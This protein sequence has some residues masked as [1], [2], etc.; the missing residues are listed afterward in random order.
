MI[1]IC[2]FWVLFVAVALRPGD[3][4][5]SQSRVVG[6]TRS[7]P[8]PLKKKPRVIHNEDADGAT[9]E[10]RSSAGNIRAAAEEWFDKLLTTTPTDIVVYAGAY[11][12]LVWLHNC[13]AGEKVY[14]RPGLNLSEPAGG[15]PAEAQQYE[16]RCLNELW[17][18]DTDLLQ[19]AVD[20]AHARGRLA[21]AEMRMS[22]Y[23]HGGVVASSYLCPKS[24]LDHPE[25]RL[26]PTVGLLDYG[27]PEVRALYLS[28]LRDIAT[29]YQVDGIELNWF[30]W[31]K[32]FAM[33]GDQ[34]GGA[35]TLTNWLIDVRRM[36]DDVSRAQ[37]RPR[38][39]LTHI[40]PATVPESLV[41]GCDVQQW[42]RKGLA[43]ILMPM[44][45]L[46]ADFNQPTVDFIAV[47]EGTSTLVYPLLHDMLTPQSL[48]TLDN[49][50]ALAA[51]QKA[52]GADGLGSFNLYTR[53][54]AWIEQVYAILDAPAAGHRGARHYQ[55]Q[56]GTTASKPIEFHEVN[57]KHSFRYRIAESGTD[58]QPSG[59]MRWRIDG[60]SK[61][62]R[63]DFE[64]NGDPLPAEILT[65]RNL[66]GGEEVVRG[67]T[68]GG[69]RHETYEA[70]QCIEMRLSDC[71][72]RSGDNEL[73][74]RW[75]ARDASNP[76]TRRL[77]IMELEVDGKP[78]STP[79][80]GQ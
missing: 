38:M 46:F 76:A 64:L 42:I 24:V 14:T 52:A 72:M 12:D 50:R 62:D 71:K 28:V 23:H 47:A 20:R 34:R 6:G 25:W 10:R 33:D 9:R 53:P 61:T 54:L 57:Q 58:A 70:G 79:S 73:G 1:R 30:R 68:S 66:P 80:P 15:S 43:D 56:R 5:Y 16:Q 44:D 41:I 40:V 69:A 67:L 19:I 39:L 60:G 55:F 32:H 29:N 78:L 2:C 51:N 11:G 7:L 18:A 8:T 49:W 48:M 21:F 75:K 35:E 4:A 13:P 27:K 37:R 26:S 36:L 45:F 65:V 3:S 74:V 77:W 31:G 63:F 22:D 59:V 17:A